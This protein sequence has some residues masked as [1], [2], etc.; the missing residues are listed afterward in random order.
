MTTFLELAKNYADYHKNPVTR[1]MHM[2]S[3]PL[4]FLSIMILLGFVRVVVL[5][6][7][8]VNMAVIMG[9]VLL[10]YYFWL[11]WRLCLA[12]FP[13]L[14]FLLWI[15]EFFSYEGPTAFALWS[16]VALLLFGGMVHFLGYFFEG[17]RP[18]IFNELSEFIYEP[19]FLAAEIFFVAGKLQSLEEILHPSPGKAD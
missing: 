10:F 18:A 16:F 11:N 8:D 6:I 1:Y 4:I 9:V 19:L 5:G 7:L 12:L 13:I 2:I 15:A 3:V 17:K 14:V